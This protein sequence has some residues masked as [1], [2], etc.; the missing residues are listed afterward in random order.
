MNDMNESMAEFLR[1]GLLSF[2]F[3]VLLFCAVFLWS[4]I[5]AVLWRVAKFGWKLGNRI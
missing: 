4:M 1:P 2:V 3:L 5:G